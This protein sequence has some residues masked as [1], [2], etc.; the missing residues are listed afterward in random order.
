MSIPATTCCGAGVATT[1]QNYVGL[2]QPGATQSTL[3]R[4]TEVDSSVTGAAGVRTTAIAAQAVTPGL[5]WVVFMFNYT[6]TALQLGRQGTSTVPGGPNVGLT[7]AAT[8]RFATC[9]TGKTSL[10]NFP[11]TT[12]ANALSA[13]TFWA[14]IA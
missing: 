2:V 9:G 11:I 13:T 8:Y 7:T 12:S 4:S 14:G 3:L 5:Y 10:G 1:G 6:G